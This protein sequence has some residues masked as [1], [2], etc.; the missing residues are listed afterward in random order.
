LP[1]DKFPFRANG[2]AIAQGQ[3][4]LQ[5]NLKFRGLTGDAAVFENHVRI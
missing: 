5:V 1:A 3:L 4:Q 2:R